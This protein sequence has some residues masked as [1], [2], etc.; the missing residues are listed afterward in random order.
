MIGRRLGRR[1]RLVG[2]MF[3]P[4]A[5]AREILRMTHA[6]ANPWPWPEP[7]R[8][9]VVIIDEGYINEKVIEAHAQVVSLT[10]N[11]PSWDQS[12]A[13]KTIALGLISS[14]GRIATVPEVE[15]AVVASIAREG[16]PSA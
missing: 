15:A 10:G 4:M 2:M 6:R 7:E 11:D 12:D 5:D 16:Q 1:R 8:T 13:V 9:D 14:E 3:D